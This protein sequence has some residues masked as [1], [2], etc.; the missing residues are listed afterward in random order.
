MIATSATDRRIIIWRLDVIDLFSEQPEVMFDEPRVT[1]IKVLPDMPREQDF[2]PNVLR[3]KWNTT[4]TC[5]AGSAED[6]TVSVWQ[7]TIHP[8]GFVQV[9]GVRSR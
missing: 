4:G 7:R 5:I 6:G 9:A 2:C 1:A 8:D 3:L